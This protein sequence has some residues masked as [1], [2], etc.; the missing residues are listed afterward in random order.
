MA[1]VPVY[2][3][4]VTKLHVPGQGLN[5]WQSVIQKGS[6]LQVSGGCSSNFYDRE[7]ITRPST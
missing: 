5:A 1:Q 3:W 4:F 2:V 6:L 7:A